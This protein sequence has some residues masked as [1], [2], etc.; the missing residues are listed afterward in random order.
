V[1]GVTAKTSGLA[2]DIIPPPLFNV[3]LYGGIP[4]LTVTV[5]NAVAGLQKVVLPLTVAVTT[6]QLTT[7]IFVLPLL[8]SLDSE[9]VL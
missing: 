8:P 4:P 3:T 7:T 9:I 6:G 1:A 5:T 2:P